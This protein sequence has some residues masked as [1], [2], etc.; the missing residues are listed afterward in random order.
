MVPVP[1]KVQILP[2][3][4]RTSGNCKK[5]VLEKG[6]AYWGDEINAITQKYQKTKH[7]ST[8]LT[9]I[10]AYSKN[11]RFG[12]FFYRNERKLSRCLN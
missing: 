6:D 9:Q 5:P 2:N 4:N 7:S 10:Q 12:K 11:I 3:T 8:K 1:L